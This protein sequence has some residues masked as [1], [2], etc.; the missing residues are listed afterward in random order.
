MLK[1]DFL[2]TIAA[3]LVL[4]NGS[5]AQGR[6]PDRPIQMLVGFPGGGGMDVACRVITRA[7]AEQGLGPI[8][9]INK[10]GASATIATSQAAKAAADGYTAL[11]AT[12]GNLGIA[13]YLYANLP[14]AEKDLVPVAQFAVSQN[15]IYCSP[16]SKAS[17]LPELMR[18]F[19]AS[20]GK[21]NYASPGAGTTAHLCFELLKASQKVAVV[22]IPFKGSPAALTAVL[23]GELD[24]GID[25]IGPALGY[26]QAGKLRPLAQTGETRSAALPDVPTLTELGIAGIPKGSYLGFMLPA[27]VP[28]PVLTSWTDAVKRVMSQPGVAKQLQQVGMDAAY[29]DGPQFTDVIQSERE[30]WRRAV[31]YS[32][33]KAI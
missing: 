6:Y 25:A 15:V 18:L 22:H 11:L 24:V 3:L 20:P 13:P 14:Y 30:F 33:A 28:A 19:R 1:R 10:P 2:S 21:F 16:D 17:S 27:G 7:L 12:S 9:I 31:K 29:L 4:P 26:I 23:G 32:G 5:R 8:A